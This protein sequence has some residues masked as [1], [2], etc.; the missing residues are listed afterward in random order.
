MA[1]VVDDPNISIV[2]YA[3]LTCERETVWLTTETGPYEEIWVELGVPVLERL[4][5]YRP[6]VALITPGVGGDEVPFELPDGYAAQVIDTG[7]VTEPAD[8]WEPFTQTASWILW[9]GWLPVPPD[10]QVYLAAWNPERVTGKVWVA[11]G[12][13]ED[14]SDVEPADFVVW[15]EETS[16]FHEKGWAIPP[17]ELDCALLEAGDDDDND[18]KSPRRRAD[19][20]TA[21]CS[22]APGGL[23]WWPL[24]LAGLIRRRSASAA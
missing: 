7:A 22:S 23:A 5:D 12:K 16:D 17:E 18:D 15:V 9:Q 24:L 1:H 3:E 13:V 21:G 14:F 20:A 8:F 10:S 2:L 6:S 19:A 11:V 4:L